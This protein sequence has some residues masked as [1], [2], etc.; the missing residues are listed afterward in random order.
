MLVIGLLILVRW[1]QCQ[2]RIIY[3][4]PKKK[5]SALKCQ[6]MKNYQGSFDLPHTYIEVKYGRKLD[7]N[8]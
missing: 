6:S 7:L 1:F 4:K 5:P 3:Q 8:I 2:V